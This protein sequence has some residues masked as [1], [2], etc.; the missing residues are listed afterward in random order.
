MA[1]ISAMHILRSCARSRISTAPASASMRPVTAAAASLAPSP[2]LLLPP[3]S[4]TLVRLGAAATTAGAPPR[5]RRGTPAALDAEAAAAAARRE[6]AVPAADDGARRGGDGGACSGGGGEAGGDGAATRSAGTLVVC[7]GAVSCGAAALRISTMARLTR[8]EARTPL[9][10]ASS[11][12]R[13]SPT[14]S[15]VRLVL[16]RS[17]WMVEGSGTGVWLRGCR[18][19]ALPRGGPEGGPPCRGPP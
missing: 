14:T 12:R 10:E 6:P 7:G 19:A 9:S 18:C 16:A 8:S 4:A 17:A 3:I 2:P 13:D 1:I 15:S 5:A 11:T